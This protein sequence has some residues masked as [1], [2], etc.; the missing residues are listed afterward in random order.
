MI[1]TTTTFATFQGQTCPE[2]ATWVGLNPLH[3]RW[4]RVPHQKR[5][6]RFGRLLT[7]RLRRVVLMLTNRHPTEQPE[8]ELEANEILFRRFLC[9]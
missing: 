5:C 9:A 2:I 7:L 1:G 8:R 3:P 4:S 6:R